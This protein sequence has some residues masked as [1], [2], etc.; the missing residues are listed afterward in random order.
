[1]A[2]IIGISGYLPDSMNLSLFWDQLL[3]NKN[4]V[5]ESLLRFNPDDNNI[6]NKRGLIPDIESFD[7]T[8]FGI[9]STQ[10]MKMD[11]QIRMALDNCLNAI[12]DA[13]INPQDLR[14]KNIG[15]YSGACFS[16]HQSATTSDPEK[17][18]GREMVGNAISMIA[19]R[20]SY[21]FDFKGPSYN[22]DTACSSSLVALDRAFDDLLSH[23]IEW[24]M[25]I[26]PVF[27]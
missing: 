8:L 17:I 19:N 9:N 16:D 11:P 2:K 20:I 10:A 24:A 27:V 12:L 7:P 23:K 5:R 22:I 21:T 1:M 4:M 14:G 13:G 3:S 15:V 26:G 6:P 25:V 18:D